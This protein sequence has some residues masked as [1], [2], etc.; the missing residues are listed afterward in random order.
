M[1]RTIKYI[2]ILI[3]KIGL[4]FDQSS[5]FLERVSYNVYPF[6]SLN[7]LDYLLSKY[8]PDL[9][10]SSTFFIE[11]G[12]ND[13]FKQSNTLFLEKIYGC[14]GI[15]VEPSPSIFERLLQNRR[16]NNIF[17]NCA[18]V[19]HSYREPYLELL[20]L[21][22]MSIACK[23]TLLNVNQHK[24]NST[25]HFRNKPYSF[26][27]PAKTLDCILREHNIR[28]VSLLSLDVEGSEMEVLNGIDFNYLSPRYILVETSS[29][30]RVFEILSRHSYILIKKLSIHDYLFKKLP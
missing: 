17:E 16:E 29:Y 2:A 6:A 5:K 14:K 12:A 11:A 27:A 19:S 25:P 10:S 1:N 15:L 18:L 30:D 7:K 24:K 9:L 26:L 3:R 4:L 8:A 23:T 21:G 28:E 22:L 13:G 20:Q